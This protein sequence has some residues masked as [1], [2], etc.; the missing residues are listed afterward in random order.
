MAYYKQTMKK[1]GNMSKA[2]YSSIFSRQM[3]AVVFTILQIFFA[4][5]SVLKPG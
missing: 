4:T 5:R 3:T 1:K 2:K